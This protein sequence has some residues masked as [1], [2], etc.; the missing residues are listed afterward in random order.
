MISWML[1]RCEASVTCT[2]TRIC[3]RLRAYAA[4]ARVGLDAPSPAGAASRGSGHCGIGEFSGVDSAID[5]RMQQH[6]EVMPYCICAR[7]R[8]L[9]DQKLSR[10]L[11]L[12]RQNWPIAVRSVGQAARSATPRPIIDS[13][14]DAIVAAATRHPRTNPCPPHFKHRRP[15]FELQPYKSLANDGADGA[16][17]SRPQAAWAASC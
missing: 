7:T 16:H 15:T 14:S 2:G 10:K 6:F 8:M 9:I 3:S 12:V 17:S 13:G 11:S 5:R 1:L 4:G